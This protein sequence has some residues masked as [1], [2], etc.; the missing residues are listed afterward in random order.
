MS[1][2]TK[3]GADNFVPANLSRGEVQRNIQP[4]N[5]ILLHP[6]LSYKKGM[7]HIL[8]V[9]EQ[10]DFLVDGDGHFRGHNVVFRRR[11]MV[12]VETIKILISLVD[13]FRMNRPKRSIRTRIAE[14]ESE[15]S[16]LDL[17]RDGIRRRRG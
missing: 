11:I 9:H 1:Q 2:A 12:G 8:R 15:L 17:D 14:R 16:G 13:Q 3:L 6:Q 10:M 7:S 4:R 5:K